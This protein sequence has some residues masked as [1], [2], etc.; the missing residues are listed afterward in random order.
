[1]IKPNKRRYTVAMYL[2]S[3]FL[4]WGR[5]FRRDLRGRPSD[6]SLGRF[7]DHF[8]NRWGWPLCCGHVLSDAEVIA[9]TAEGLLVDAGT[10]E[11]GVR[12]VIA[13]PKL[14]DWVN[15]AWHGV[16]IQR[17]WRYG[18]QRADGETVN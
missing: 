10:D 4:P 7:R 3:G 18:G 16:V 8:T 9:W 14:E 1:M 15:A 13:G 6:P 17:W 12:R 2:L 5:D 11:H